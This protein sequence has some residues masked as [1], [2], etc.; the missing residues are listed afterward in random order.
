MRKPFHKYFD[1]QTVKVGDRITTSRL[2][3]CKITKIGKDICRAY[4]ILTKEKFAL[5]GIALSDSDLIKRRV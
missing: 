1:G 2:G 3:Q 4:N 5:C